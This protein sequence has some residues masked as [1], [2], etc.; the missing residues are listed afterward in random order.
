MNQPI[1]KKKTR[2]AVG[3]VVLFIHVDFVPA[4]MRFGKRFFPWEDELRGITFRPM[5]CKE[6]HI[7]PGEWDEKPQYDGFIFHDAEG[8]QW[9]NQY[10]AA[11]Y[12]QLDDSQNWVA[13][14]QDMEAHP[15]FYSMEDAAK[16][17]DAVHRGVTTLLKEDQPALASSLSDH[18]DEVRGKIVELGFEVFHE[19]ITVKT[20]EG[21]VET[22]PSIKRFRVVPAA[23]TA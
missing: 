4:R 17:L 3:D 12:G 7:V 23:V 13:H 1:E 11:A 10:P 16:Y 5:T 19:P 2:Y 8:K 6:H 22:V 14:P 15:N 9:N 18:L 20:V 21:A